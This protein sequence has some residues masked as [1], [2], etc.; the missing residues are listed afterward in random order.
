MGLAGSQSAEPIQR[1]RT[2]AIM[3]FRFLQPMANAVLIEKAVP[4]FAATT[5][6]RRQFMFTVFSRTGRAVR[7]CHVSAAGG[8]VFGG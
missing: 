7:R 8:M 5:V 4:R 6:A 2:M 1:E 3:S